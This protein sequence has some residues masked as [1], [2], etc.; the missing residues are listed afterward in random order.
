MGVIGDHIHTRSR[1]LGQSTTAR[2]A[3]AEVAELPRGAAGAA[4][5]AMGRVTAWID[6]SA[7]AAR[8][9]LAAHAGPGHARRKRAARHTASA[10]VCRIRGEIDT[11]PSTRARTARAATPVRIA[12][13]Y[14][15]CFA[16]T[17]TEQPNDT[18]NH[19]STY[20]LSHDI[21]RSRQS[22]AALDLEPASAA[23]QELFAWRHHTAG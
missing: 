22:H 6:A 3:H 19:P 23:T 4:G 5:A 16:R 12:P 18:P 10:T 20:F 17:A 15:R 8:E 13:A 21:L 1:A 14:W 2:A 11:A 9:A 7:R